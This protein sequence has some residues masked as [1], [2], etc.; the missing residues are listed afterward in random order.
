M[1]SVPLIAEAL[2]QPDPDQVRDSNLSRF[3]G[4][5][6]EKRSLDLRDH[7][8]LYDWS[9]RDLEGFWSAITEFFDVRFSR[10]AE[11]VLRQEADPLRTKWFP[12]GTLNYAEHLLRFGSSEMNPSDQH[13]AVLFCSE[14][15]ASTKRQTLTRAELIGRVSQLSTAL[16]GLGVQCGDR[17]AGY[18]PNRLETLIAFLATASLGAIWSNC[19]PEL[20]SQGVLGRLS[21]IGPKVMVAIGGYQY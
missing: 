18:L 7:R 8:A 9:V 12:G 3:R 1:E 13:T 14:T 15:G 4:W 19:A 2:W 17:V 20:S 16:E 21:Q 11:R 10:P 6:L 5:L